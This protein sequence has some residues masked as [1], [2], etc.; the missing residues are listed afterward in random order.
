MKAVATNDPLG[1]AASSVFIGVFADIASER[2][3]HR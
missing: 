1:D 3:R 2:W